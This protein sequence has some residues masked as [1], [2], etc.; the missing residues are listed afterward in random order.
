MHYYC[1]CTVTPESEVVLR[2]TGQSICCMPQLLW[3]MP[4]QA[5]KEGFKG[6]ARANRERAQDAGAPSLLAGEHE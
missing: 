3:A 6:N 1:P 4:R 5:Q 2:P